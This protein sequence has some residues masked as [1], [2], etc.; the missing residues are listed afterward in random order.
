[1]VRPAVSHISRKTS[2]MWGGY[3]GKNK[4]LARGN[5]VGHPA[6]VAGMEYG[7][8]PNVVR[9]DEFGMTSGHVRA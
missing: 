9:M 7:R 4:C 1:M 3:R 8:D 5:R 2:E 6:L